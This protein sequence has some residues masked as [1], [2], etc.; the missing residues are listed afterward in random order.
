MTLRVL[1]VIKGLGPG[2]AEQ[3]L[4]NQARA[5]AAGDAEFE[6]AYLVSWKNHLVPKLE[7][8]GW[9]VHCLGGDRIWDP[10]WVW[11]L[12]RLVTSTAVDVVHAH[13]PLVAA[14]SRLVL[15]TIPKGRRPA[16]VY[17]EHNEWGRHNVWTRRCNRW[18]IGLEDRVLAVSEGVKVSMPAGVDVEVLVH[19]IDVEAVAAQRAHRAEVRAELG[20]ADDEWVV[21]IVANL[22]RE[23]AY[24]VLLE[25]AAQA[26]AADPGLR[27]VSVGQG[28]LEDE[29]REHHER[30]GL[31]DRFL[32]LGYRDDATRVMG[33]FDTF[34]LT[35][36]HEGLPV[37]LMDALALG[38]PVIATAVG[39]IPEALAGS[40]AVVVDDGDVEAL[41]AAYAARSA[42]TADVA[43]F[44]ATTSS[45]RLLEIY[46]QS[47][48][49][50]DG[51]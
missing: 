26:L 9:H 20:I 40:D 30:L 5:T 17:T 46:R 21:G 4:V 47:A 19:G 35:S 36:H 33:A 2:G 34:T 7:D 50:T 8:A 45:A 12:R 29:I 44:D 18:T 41:A 24:D 37:S 27:F 1:H 13:S 32:L 11:R 10:R 43:R 48:S 6:A 38:L 39:G 15:C 14:V 42:G 49:G 28:P 23:K 16:S 22:R 31:G 3:L 51:R 25:A